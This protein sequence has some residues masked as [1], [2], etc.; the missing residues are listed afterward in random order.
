MQLFIVKLDHVDWDTY[1]SAVIGCESKQKLEE[2]LADGVFRTDDSNGNYI[3]D[4][5]R[6]EYQNGFEIGRWQKVSSIEPLGS[7]DYKTAKE[8]V[9]FLSSFN[10]G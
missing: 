10:A 6:V 7:S 9:V 2:L 3:G 4:S 8:A 1:D 5:P